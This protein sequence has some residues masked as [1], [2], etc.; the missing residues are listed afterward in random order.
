MLGRLNSNVEHA[1]LVV[2]IFRLAHIVA[3]AVQLG[4]LEAAQ[5][6]ALR[7]LVVRLKLVSDQFGVVKRGIASHFLAESL[8]VASVIERRATD[9]LLGARESQRNILVL[10]ITPIANLAGVEVVRA[11]LSLRSHDLVAKVNVDGAVKLL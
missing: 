7:H 11:C 10:Y 5:G 2:Q 9:V 4:E 1:V 8:I 3:L 6:E